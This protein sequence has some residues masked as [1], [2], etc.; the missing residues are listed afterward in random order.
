MPSDKG[1]RWYAVAVL[2]VSSALNYLDRSVLSALMPTLRQEFELSGQD[3]GNVIAAFSVTYAFASPAMG[4]LIDRMGLKWGASAIVGFWS[5]ISIG[6]GFVGGFTSLLVMRALLGVAESGGVPATGKGFAMYLAPKDRAL[7]TAL[8]QVGISAGAM[9]APLLTEL[10]SA[11]YGWRAT[12]MVA[13]VLG[14]LWIPV[15][16]R[17]S[18]TAPQV[19]VKSDPVRVSHR[20]ILGDRRYIALLLANILSMTVYSLW[21]AWTTEFLHARYGLTQSAANLQY[22]WIP[23]VFAT[24]GGLF[25]G[26][27]ARRLIQA[28]GEIVPIRLRIAAGAAVFTLATALA[29]MAGGPGAATAAVCLSLFAVT[30]MSVNFYAIPLDLFGASHA[31]FAVSFLTGV[32]GLMQAFLAPQIGG[33]SD[34]VGWTPVCAVIAVLPITSVLVLRAALGRW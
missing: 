34:T 32:F 24:L 11:A 1:L 16:V 26:W 27:I 7:G 20:A 10:V 9:A 29:P 6:T 8:N 4:L 21:L 28:G 33:W 12:F 25:G 17:S 31:A 13:G 30:C 22:A 15:W 5:A 3:L 14:F 18:S 23:P 19:H 2:V